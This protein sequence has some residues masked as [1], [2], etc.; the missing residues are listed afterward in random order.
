LS[1]NAKVQSW[2]RGD[3]NQV[4]RGYPTQNPQSVNSPQLPELYSLIQMRISASFY[5]MMG[6]F[7]P[8]SLVLPTQSG[9]GGGCDQAGFGANVAHNCVVNQTLFVGRQSSKL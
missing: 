8:F 4:H 6:E 3:I 9:C 1:A 5:I 2:A 7:L